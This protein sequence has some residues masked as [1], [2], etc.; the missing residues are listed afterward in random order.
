MKKIILCITILLVWS[1]AAYAQTSK[2]TGTITDPE[3]NE[4]VPGATIVIK[5]K[6][7]GTISDAQGNFELTTGVKPPF[8]LSISSIGY[9]NQEVQVT[10]EEKIAIKL[11]P[12]S[13]LMNEVVF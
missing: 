11:L 4:P 3:T 2:I 10:S 12:K 9:E 13:E 7:T 8:T 6:L 1:A 5:G